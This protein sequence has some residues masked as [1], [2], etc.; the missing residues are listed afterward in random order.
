KSGQLEI[1]IETSENTKVDPVFF[2]Y[3][4]LQIEMTLDPLHFGNIQA[5]KGTEANDGKDKLISFNVMPEEEEVL[6]DSADVTDF[7]LETIKINEGV[8]DLEDGALDLSDGASQLSIGSNEFLNGI[9]EL[10]NS[11][12]E[13]VSGSNEILNAFNQINNVMDNMPDI[14]SNLDEEL[15][16]VP[17]NLK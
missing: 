2:E 11:S 7:E 8:A 14:P 15:N 4:L 10:S 3:Y 5:P 16:E 9:N 12:G 13:L 17:K 6:I 1:Q